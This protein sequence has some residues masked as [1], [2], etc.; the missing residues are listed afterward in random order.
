M[1][2]NLAALAVVGVLI[3]SALAFRGSPSASGGASAVSASGGN[4]SV[5][6]GKQIVEIT[7]KG[8]YAPTRTV[9][10]AGIPTVLRFKTNGTF[11]CSSAIVIPSLS[12]SQLLPQTGATDIDAGV[13]V[14][15]QLAGTCSM[16]MYRFAVDFQA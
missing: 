12:V 6:D 3:A 8:G 10:K 2:N 7:A 11:D 14:A 5:V 1:K 4:V 16:G 15:G 13:P 9:A